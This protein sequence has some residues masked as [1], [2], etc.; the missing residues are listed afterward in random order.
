MKRIILLSVILLSITAVHAAPVYYFLV[1]TYTGSAPGHSIYAYAINLTSGDATLLSVVDSIINPSYL[2]LS[3]D[4]RFVYAVSENGAASTVSSFTFDKGNGRMSLINTVK[5]PGADPCYLAVTNKHVIT[6]NYSGGSISVFGRNK[7]GSLTEAIQVIQH[8]GSSVNANRQREAHVHQTIFTTD[9]KFLLVNDL[10]TD[11][12]TVY[13][14]HPNNSEK[15]LEAVDS[16]LVRRGGG[17]RHLAIH[18]YPG[19]LHTDKIAE[20]IRPAYIAYIL[21]ELDGAV[22]MVAIDANG[23]LQLLNETSVVRNGFVEIGAADIHTS[24][25]GK[26]LYATN[27][28]T[29]NDIT[30][31]ALTDDGVPEFIQQISS[32]GVGPR[33]FAL[34]P[35]G[36]A[37][38]VA[39]QQTGNIVM[40]KR[41]INTGLL[42]DSGRQIKVDRPVCILFFE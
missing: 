15:V 16:L 7:D 40:F 32:G 6:A 9:Y 22:S 14:Y 19:L 10:G 27:R 17:P 38:F 21:H 41:D 37:I 33:N 30:G 26:F 2:A 5:S 31:F 35:D 36:R 24:P 42:T 12:V 11:Y 18:P 39:N 3:S 25:E 1:G 8:A 34:T 20:G 28:G 23:Q 4:K 29:A 13:R